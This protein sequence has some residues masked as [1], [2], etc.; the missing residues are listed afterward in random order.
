[1]DQLVADRWTL[2]GWETIARR[3]VGMPDIAST[4]GFFAGLSRLCSISLLFLANGYHCA[5]SSTGF[6]GCK[7]LRVI[8]FPMFYSHCNIESRLVE[9]MTRQLREEAVSS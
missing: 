3:T 4:E 7:L 5:S 1:M 8:R 2:F 6:L 9:A